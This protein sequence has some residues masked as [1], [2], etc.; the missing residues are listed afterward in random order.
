[1]GSGGGG[2]AAPGNRRRRR[3]II[4]GDD[5]DPRT[6]MNGASASAADMA[7]SDAMMEGT[8]MLIE[9]LREKVAALEDRCEKMDR[10][11]VRRSVSDVLFL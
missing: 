2:S 6:M 10:E 3:R 11:K 5:A 9:S 7:R 8:R 1:V 4:S